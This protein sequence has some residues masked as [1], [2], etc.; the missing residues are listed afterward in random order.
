M[1]PK[2]LLINY[3]VVD[4]QP[5]PPDLAKAGNGQHSNKIYLNEY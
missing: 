5:L 1:A 2:K 4:F 3:E